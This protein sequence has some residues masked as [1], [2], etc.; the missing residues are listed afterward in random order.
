VP[1]LRFGSKI[2]VILVVERQDGQ[3]WSEPALNTRV[4]VVR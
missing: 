1:I 3:L 2:L 4:T